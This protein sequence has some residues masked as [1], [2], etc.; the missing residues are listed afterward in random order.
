MQMS[1]QL[2]IPE[3]QSLQPFQPVHALFKKIWHFNLIFIF[4]IPDSLN[5]I[6][7]FLLVTG[8]YKG[9]SFWTIENM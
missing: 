4:E 8:L 5:V 6:L 3:R 2:L 7:I 1:L 9:L